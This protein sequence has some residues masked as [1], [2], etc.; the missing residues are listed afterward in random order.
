M[1]ANQPEDVRQGMSDI[2]TSPD[3]QKYQERE[4]RAGGE[5]MDTL[6]VQPKG[7][8]VG[9][10]NAYVAPHWT[11]N[12]NA[13]ANQAKGMRQQSGAQQAMMADI[14]K[15]RAAAEAYNK[16]IQQQA[17]G[18]QARAEYNAIPAEAAGTLPRTDAVQQWQDRG[19]EMMMDPF[20]GVA[21]T[22]PVAGKGSV[23]PEWAA[24]PKRPNVPLPGEG[25]YGPMPWEPGG[26]W[27]LNVD[28]R[29]SMAGFLRKPHKSG[30]W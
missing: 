18:Q 2:Y 7:A 26:D 25:K 9:P 5:H 16:F 28:P 14:L 3:I 17:Q 24:A 21:P 1:L 29:A 19:N 15:K 8:G 11:Q 30:G 27:D 22:A 23:P 4:Y 12:L 10:Y 6:G 13:A 20:Q